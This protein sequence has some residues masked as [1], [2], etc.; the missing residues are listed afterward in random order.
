MTLTHKPISGIVSNLCKE[1]SVRKK[2]IDLGA[3]PALVA[4][5]SA[6]QPQLLKNALTALL[7]LCGDYKGRDQVMAADPSQALLHI[8][9]SEYR[10]LQEL[11]LNLVATAARSK[12]F[13]HALC[14]CRQASCRGGK[15]ESKAGQGGAVRGW[16]QGRK[17][18]GLEREGCEKDP[19]RREI[20][21]FP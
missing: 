5:L 15:R 4:L 13:R 7:L 19:E 6:P 21:F 14:T 2:A 10:E 8:L 12:E 20:R 1:F 18:T 16:R 9:D 11:T 3:V 17:A